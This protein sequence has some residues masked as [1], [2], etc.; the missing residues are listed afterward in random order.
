[1]IRDISPLARPYAY[2]DRLRTLLYPIG[3][4]SVLQ[5]PAPNVIDVFPS[6][7]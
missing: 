4:K 2:D 6:R 1:M 3:I 7:I 5:N